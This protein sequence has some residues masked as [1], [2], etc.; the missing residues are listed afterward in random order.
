M[1]STV[2][3]T[4]F[5]CSLC[6]EETLWDASKL[7]ISL[8]LHSKAVEWLCIMP[9]KW[10]CI[11]TAKSNL[12]VDCNLGTFLLELL[13][14]TMPNHTHM[15][16][17]NGR[18]TMT[19]KCARLWIL[20]VT[21]TWMTDVNEACTLN[22]VEWLMVYSTSATQTNGGVVHYLRRLWV[23]NHAA[24]MEEESFIPHCTYSSTVKQQQRV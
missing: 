7:Q 14:V 11:F 24:M 13:S 22:T 23:D 16:S 21:T 17:T 20:Q 2:A 18:N 12:M 15:Q 5:A 3:Y 8:F 6:M 9:C 19:N 10:Q 4:Q 1:Y